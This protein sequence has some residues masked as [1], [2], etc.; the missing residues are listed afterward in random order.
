MAYR[1]I[2]L[3]FL[4]LFLL[5]CSKEKRL[6]IGT[7]SRIH[8]L[9]SQHKFYDDHLP[10]GWVIE[11]AEADDLFSRRGRLPNIYM[12]RKAKQ[13]G[14]HI[15]SGEENFIL[16]RY[17]KARLPVSPYLY[18]NWN[19]SEHSGE[20]HP[21][22]LVVGFYGGNPKREPL[23]D[24]SFIWKGAKLPPFDRV[25]SIGFNEMALR[26]GNIF[27]KGEM[28]YYVQRGGIEQT[29]QWHHEATDLSL[30]Y[31][32]AWPD[33]DQSNVFITFVGM[34]GQSRKD[35]GGGITFSSIWLSR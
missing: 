9:T 27:S 33:D 22:S 25:L 12:D 14:V 10:P 4:P 20:D 13:K 19:I 17:T 2:V 30:I 16:A 8:V 1:Y 28:K 31:K 23:E 3:V 7:G 15:Q 18:W 6:E 32:W 5:G 26:R 35:S 34:M 29:N 24:E 21:V 11:G